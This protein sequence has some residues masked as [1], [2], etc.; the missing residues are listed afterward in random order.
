V[1]IEGYN[2][3][4]A[5]TR[6]ICRNTRQT[7]SGEPTVGT[8]YVDDT[9]RGPLPGQIVELQAP[10][11]LVYHWWQKSDSGRFTAEGWPSY[12]LQ[13]TGDSET[14]VRHHAKLV[15]YGLWRLAGPM[16]RRFAIKERTITI[17]ALKA[18]FERDR[19]SAPQ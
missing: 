19:H 10:H 14:L 12:Q 3:W 1:D 15:P 4:M 17:D 11:T 8:T 2:A 7:S 18:S 6:S 5:G 13:S 16:L 9:T